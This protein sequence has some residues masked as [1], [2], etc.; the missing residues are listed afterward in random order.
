M[1][2]T[3]FGR[4][5]QEKAV[6]ALIDE[7]RAMADRLAEAKPH[8]AE[9]HAAAA[10]F[11]ARAYLAEGLDLTTLATWKAPEV[12]RFVRAAQGKIA[13]LRKARDY[14]S[15]DGLATWLHS[16]RAVQEPRVAPAVRDIWAHLSATGQNVEAML[17]DLLEDAGMPAAAGRLTPDGLAGE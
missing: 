5:K 12:Q 16:A 14:V 2:G 1:A 9:Q 6:Q 13:A 17:A 7:A 11:W 8:A 15:S 4:W 10:Q 3:D